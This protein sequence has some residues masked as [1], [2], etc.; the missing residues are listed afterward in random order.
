MQENLSKNIIMGL[1]RVRV[2][3]E[4]KDIVEIFNELIKIKHSLKI[5]IE[6]HTGSHL[7]Y[8]L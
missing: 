3:G 8:P 2:G 4:L 1:G 6:S 7:E 5:N